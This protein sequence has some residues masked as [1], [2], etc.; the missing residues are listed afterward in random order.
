MDFYDNEKANALWKT[1]PTARDVDCAYA[2]DPLFEEGTV[3]EKR[4]AIQHR[5]F[6]YLGTLFERFAADKLPDVSVHVSHYEVLWHLAASFGLKEPLI[7]GEVI[8]LELTRS[9]DNIHVRATFREYSREFDCKLP[10]D[11][12][13]SQFKA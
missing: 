13:K 9:S 2:Q 10:A 5:F 4:S 6:S 11:L 7:H 12:F 1:F 3:I 8:K